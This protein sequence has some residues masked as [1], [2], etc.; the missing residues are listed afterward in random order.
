MNTCDTCKHWEIEAIRAHVAEATHA[1][2]G[3][4]KVSDNG[5]QFEDGAEDNEG[6]G[7]IYTGPKFGCIHHE[8]K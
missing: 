5:L 7:G 1:H 3:H 4:P 2:C 8:A 6:Y